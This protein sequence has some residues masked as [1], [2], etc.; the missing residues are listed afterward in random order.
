MA[1]RQWNDLNS[2]EKIE[3]LRSDVVRLFVALRE[4]AAEQDRL[5]AAVSEATERPDSIQAKK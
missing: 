2:A 4:M 3:D 1:E 5:R